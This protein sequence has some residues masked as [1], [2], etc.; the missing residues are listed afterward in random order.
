MIPII[1]AG[2]RPP[3]GCAEWIERRDGGWF[4]ERPGLHFYSVEDDG[5]GLISV[6]HPNVADGLFG[7]RSGDLTIEFI[8]VGKYS[9]Y[10]AATPEAAIEEH[11]K[12]L[13]FGRVRV[14]SHPDGYLIDSNYGRLGLIESDP[15]H[16]QVNIGKGDALDATELA[17]LTA[18]LRHVSEFLRDGGGVIGELVK[19]VTS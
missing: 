10:W 12:T 8:P 16:F 13:P 3:E 6:A 19:G 11:C 4:S 18:I 14:A 7:S 9:T 15:K 1:A 2:E 5:S 17:Q